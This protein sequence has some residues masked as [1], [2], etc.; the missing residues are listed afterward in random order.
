MISRD[1]VMP[2]LLAACPSFAPIWQGLEHDAVHL[3]EESGTRLHYGDASVFAVHLVDLMRHR[4]D[5]QI[6]RS[7][8]VIE[9]LHVE[10]D[11]YVR[12]LATIGFLEGV[13]N[14]AGHSPDVSPDDFLPYLGAE[15]RRWWRGLDAFWSGAASAVQAV[16]D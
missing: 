7:F 11:A 16:D 10:G 6:R 3:D 15:T 12:E 13:Q 4:H 9:T 1:D 2:M 14:H 8:E 5:E